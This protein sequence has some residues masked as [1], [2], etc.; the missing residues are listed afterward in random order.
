M[1]IFSGAQVQKPVRVSVVCGRVGSGEALVLCQFG[2]QLGLQQPS[3][4]R[5]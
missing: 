2:G 5:E 4:Y 3:G 1:L